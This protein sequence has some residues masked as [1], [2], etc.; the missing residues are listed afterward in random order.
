MGVQ[1]P[2]EK[3]QFWGKVASIVKYRDFLPWDVQKRLN[4]SICCLGCGL[5]W[6]KRSTSW[7]VFARWRQC[8]RRHSAV[9]CAKTAEPIHLPFGLWT[10][11]CP[12]KCKFNCIRQVA[13]MCT[14]SI[15]FTRWHWS[16]HHLANTIEPSVC[17]GDAA[18]CQVTLTT[19]Y[20]YFYD[21]VQNDNDSSSEMN[22]L[23]RHMTLK[24]WMSAEMCWYNKAVSHRSAMY[25]V[26]LLF[27]LLLLL[28]W[29]NVRKSKHMTE[30]EQNIYKR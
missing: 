12:R 30:H 17:G 19:C 11:V 13:P 28:Q 27:F 9:S 25:S 16:Q 20:Y 10:W 7:T 18:L 1:I 23:A 2:H 8:S 5:G 29:T 4:R 21:D 14:R 6:A 26:T 24:R 3:G 15:V 22:V